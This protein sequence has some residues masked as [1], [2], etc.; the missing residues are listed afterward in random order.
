MTAL[1]ELI[2]TTRAAVEQ[3]RRSTSDEELVH[4]KEQRLRTD[5]IRPF[6]AALTRPGLSLI[7]EHK[8]R[9]P[10]AGTIRDGLPLE[11]V[12]S[13]YERGGAAALSVLTETSQFGGSL[14]DLRAARVASRLP[15]LRKDFV[16]DTFQLHES[17][18]AGADAVLLIVAGLRPDDLQALHA[19][20]ISLGLDA[21]VEVHDREEL[22]AAS[23][24][25]ATLIGI[26]NRDLATLAVDLNKTFEL[27]PHVPDGVAVVAESGFSRPEQLE[28]VAHQGVDAVLIG[29]SLMRAPNIEAACRALF[30][31]T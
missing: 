20:A 4:A 16:I 26:N 1:Q 31:C 9:S 2:A 3:R 21:L 28:Q 14:D 7:A 5:P 30:S 8:R 13:A 27:V 19:E 24:L 6:K 25:G 17:L 15:I 12:V 10:S 18:A 23:A 22:E 29:E 11:H